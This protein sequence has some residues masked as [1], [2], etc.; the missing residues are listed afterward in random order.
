MVNDA[1]LM[2][3]IFSTMASTGKLQSDA[4]E[5][6]FGG[7]LGIANSEGHVWLEQRKFMIRALK[8]FGF[9]SGTMLEP[10]ILGECED[11]CE[12]INQENTTNQSKPLQLSQ[13]LMRVSTNT[14]WN[15]VTGEKMKLAE[16]KIASIL[17]E[18][19][20]E[21]EVA[22]R[23]GLAFSSNMK[24][25]APQLSGYNEFSKSCQKLHKLIRHYFKEHQTVREK[26][27]GIAKDL[28]DAYLEQVETCQDSGSTFYAET[29]RKS[30]FFAVTGL[31][32]AGSET[33][34]AT[35]NWLL[36]YLT[37]HPQIQK[38]V[39]KEIDFIIGEHRDPSLDDRKR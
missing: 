11:L 28:I 9:G 16:S 33:S 7:P 38:R 22:T 17:E 27:G 26:T 1:N 4:F 19:C 23:R 25:W 18:V 8:Q 29:G 12:W 5:C 15:M 24:Y 37:A 32:L 36:F 21:L 34:G 30:S 31:L 3:E 35:I 2:R 6:M 20:H 10:V 13:I 39:Q 14:L